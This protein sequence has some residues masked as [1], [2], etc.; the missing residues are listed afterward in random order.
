MQASTFPVFDL[1]R[2]EKAGPEEKKALGA[3]VDRIC[4]TTGF[5]AVTN[6]GG[7]QI[8]ARLRADV[9]I[10]AGQTARL[11]FNLD[12]AVFFDPASQLRIA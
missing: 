6:H 12:K 3:E 11:A 2:F 8:V 1:D 9:P 7:K 4:R 10:T 5:L